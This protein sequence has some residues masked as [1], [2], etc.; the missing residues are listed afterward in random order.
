MSCR[1]LFVCLVAV[2]LAAP[3]VAQTPDVAAADP[4]SKIDAYLAPYLADGHL[5]GTLLV[6]K[7]GAMVYE[8]SFGMAN[9]ELK[10]PNTPCWTESSATL[11]SRPCCERPV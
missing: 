4:T 6:A 1:V 7:N 3:S 9:Y 8:R 5:S 10:D 2:A 11:P